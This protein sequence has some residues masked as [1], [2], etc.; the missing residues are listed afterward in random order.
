MKPENRRKTHSVTIISIVV[1]CIVLICASGATAAIPPITGPITDIYYLDQENQTYVI[2]GDCNVSAPTALYV[3]ADNITITSNGSVTLTCPDSG[4][5]AKGVI[6][7]ED[8]Q[9]TSIKNVTFSGFLYGIECR[10][11]AG[12]VTIDT[13]R[14]ENGTIASQPAIRLWNSVDSLTVVDSY[15]CD[16]EGMYSNSALL[17]RLT[18]R[19]N[20]FSDI[21]DFAFDPLNLYDSV[22]ENNTFTRCDYGIML[23]NANPATDAGGV[24][25]RNNTFTEFSHIG[26]RLS[27]IG[28]VSICDNTIEGGDLWVTPSSFS[29]GIWLID[30]NN[31]D[32]SR[33][34]IEACGDYG[35]IC[36]ESSAI[37]GTGNI[38]REN[39][40]G[41]NIQANGNRDFVDTYLSANI[42]SGISINKDVD[43]N[44]SF[45]NITL[46]DPK[47]QMDFSGKNVRL[48]EA[49]AYPA[50]V[51]DG[52]QFT[53]AIAYI[54]EDA[55]VADV[56]RANITF[57]YTTADIAGIT[58][59]GLTVLRSDSTAG[60]LWSET[61]STVN[62]T[63]RT[64]FT[65]YT[66]A[67]GEEE[68]Y[69]ALAG[70]ITP[71]EV[72]IMANLSTGW[73]MVSVPVRN[74]TYDIPPLRYSRPFTDITATPTLR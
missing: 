19:N 42:N 65:N 54:Q 61:D 60:R 56:M 25:I 31:T 30:V 16:Q 58:E 9:Y 63:T 49:G 38:L 6:I 74:A 45:T 47:T 22:I 37:T 10:N 57:H 73:N 39:D 44:D 17:T 66:F 1:F 33:N 3:Q 72:T 59:S 4:L 62:T 32:I 27:G 21:P 29:T 18:I 71:A 53:G 20:T 35:I 67:P 12:N 13:C 70:P 40:Q 34:T 11:G 5:N 14:V 8:V 55:L 15:F 43:G 7:S 2:T 64:V 52:Y 23:N 46:S 69:F 50:D 26:I 41:L 68:L 51:P 24:I 36:F 28:G 48:S